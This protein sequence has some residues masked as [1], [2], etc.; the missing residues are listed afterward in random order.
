MTIQSDI[1]M[2]MDEQK[3]TLLVMLDLNAAFDKTDHS[4]LLEILRSGFGVDGTASKWLRH[5]FLK[6]LMGTK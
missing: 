4:T 1:L 3:V 2:N 5:I 6:E